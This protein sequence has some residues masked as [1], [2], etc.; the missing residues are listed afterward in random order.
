MRIEGMII[1]D[2][3]TWYFNK[4]SQ[5]LFLEMKGDNKRECWI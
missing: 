2:E 3:S 5:L 1:E 4:F